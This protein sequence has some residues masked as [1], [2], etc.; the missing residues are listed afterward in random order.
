MHGCE[1]GVWEWKA[2]QLEQEVLTLNTNNSQ[3]RL[4][5]VAST[6]WQLFRNMKSLHE[7]NGGVNYYTLALLHQVC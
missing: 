3:T 1:H 6:N 5:M 7:Q 2:E 4:K